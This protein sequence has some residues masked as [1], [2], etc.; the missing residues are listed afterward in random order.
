MKHP[1]VLHSLADLYKK[2]SAGLW[3]GTI[4]STS[5][6]TP[7]TS[8]EL[9]QSIDEH[10]Q[11]L[12][13]AGVNCG[14]KIIVRAS[15]CEKTAGAFIALWHLG[16]VAVPVKSADIDY[17][18]EH[19]AKDCNARYVFTP[20]SGDMQPLQSYVEPF[21]LFR[22]QSQR[23]VT[24][25]DLALIIYTSGSTGTP[26]GVVLSHSNVLAALRAIVDYIGITDTDRILCLSQFSFDYGLYQLLFCLYC[27]CELVLYT[28][29]HH[30]LKLVDAIDKHRIT[31]LPTLPLIATLFATGMRLKKCELP[32]LR[33]ITNTGGH[34]PETMI[35]QLQQQLPALEIVPMYG[36]TES[37]RALYLPSQFVTQKRGSVGIPMPGMDAKVF[38]RRVDDE[39]QDYYEE[40]APNEIGTLFV[41]GSSIMQGYQNPSSTGGAKI[42]DGNYRDDL[43]LN[44]GDLFRC[45][46][47]GFLYF[48]GR[49]KE[50]IK[51]GGFCLY[52]SEIEKIV[53]QHPAV[54][55]VVLV[56]TK[57]RFEN[58]VGC[59]FVKLFDDTQRRD[60]EQ[61]LNTTM[62]KDYLPRQIRYV[63]ELL[64]TPNGKIDKQKMLQACA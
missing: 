37:K 46:E 60:F 62:D 16:A 54:D 20:T 58:E 34:L 17:T 35:D 30:P 12:H 3:S 18:L 24:G 29:M 11:T 8:A 23:R 42:F 21:A 26:K 51:Q 38:R 4:R 36:L 61:W 10:L 7:V 64:F 6:D 48:S 63:Q 28:D 15:L 45:D 41:R 50:L 55:M 33:K 53:R 47:D 43:W 14:D 2:I 49:E 39:G 27:D 13:A 9:K 19:I 32:Y 59:L 57:D 44:T 5:D 25:C 22:V 31:L 40:A 52:P 1:A 56:G